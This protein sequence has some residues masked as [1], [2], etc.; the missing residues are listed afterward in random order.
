MNICNKCYN[1]LEN[2]KEKLVKTIT[3]RLIGVGTTFTI[4][5]FI[6]ED[7]KKAATLAAVDTVIKTFFY[8]FHESIYETMKEKKVC[9]YANYD[10]E[11]ID[12]DYNDENKDDDYNDEDEYNN[13][14]NDDYNDSKKSD[15]N[16]ENKKNQHLIEENSNKV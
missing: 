9:I 2:R 5:F 15:E 10:N 11:T 12:N 14:E 4:G 3:W 16:T 13:N 8:Y 7:A 1:F 6:Q